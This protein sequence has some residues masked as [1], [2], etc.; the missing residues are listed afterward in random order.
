MT[1]LYNEKAR[2]AVCGTETEYTGIRSTNA[3]GSS[4]LD[5]RPPEMKRSTIFAWVQRCPECGYC[6]S[7]IS[8][9]PSQAATL[10]HSPEYARQL[11]DSTFPELANGF[12]CKALID[13]SAADYAAA[14]WALIHAAWACDD[15]EKPEP[16]KTCRS[17]AID[18]IE[19]VLANGQQ[20]AEQDGADTAI[21]VDLL[22]R[23]GRLIEARHLISTKRPASTEDIISKMLDFQYV[24]LAKG[25]ETCHTIAEALGENE[26]GEQ[27]AG[28][29]ALPRAVQP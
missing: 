8:K 4:D 19:K 1:R 28:A 10:V 17:K 14:A 2:C 20:V 12:L 27:S 22:R 15:A 24:L 11:T 18:L 3:F 9:A 23:A 25:D 16:A 13:E 29:D 26:Q 6:A 21:R 5:T 7:D